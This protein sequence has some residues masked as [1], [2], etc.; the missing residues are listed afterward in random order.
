MLSVLEKE[1]SKAIDH[2]SHIVELKGAATESA[3]IKELQW[4]CVWHPS[5]ASRF[6]SR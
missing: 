3:L 6:G 4:G 1:L 2:G 5:S